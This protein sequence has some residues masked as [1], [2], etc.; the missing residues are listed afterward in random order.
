M[1]SRRTKHGG[2][3]RNKKVSVPA[4]CN[5]FASR[6]VVKTLPTQHFLRHWHY[7]IVACVGKND[8]H[9]YFLIPVVVADCYFRLSEV[10]SE[11]RSKGNLSHMLLHECFETALGQDT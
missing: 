9:S 11:E 1:T 8:D 5:I 7:R 2:V 6:V 3:H 10:F 4:I